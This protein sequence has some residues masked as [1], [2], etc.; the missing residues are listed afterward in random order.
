MCRGFFIETETERN[1]YGLDEDNFSNR[2][3]INADISNTQSKDDDAGK[4]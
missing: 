4:C 3:G 1:F 2:V